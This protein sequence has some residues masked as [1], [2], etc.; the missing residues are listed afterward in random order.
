MSS[1]QTAVPISGR[2]GWPSAGRGFVDLVGKYLTAAVADQNGRVFFGLPA[3]KPVADRQTAGVGVW[4]RIAE[5]TT[6]DGM[7]MPAP[8]PY[9]TLIRWEWIVTAMVTTERPSAVPAIGSRN[10]SGGVISPASGAAVLT[11]RPAPL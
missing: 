2:L 6:P 10:K 5:V 4:I 1:G 7:V 9:T 11:C 3:S 8:G